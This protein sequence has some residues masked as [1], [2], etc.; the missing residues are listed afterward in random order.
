MNQTNFKTMKR[1]IKFRAWNLDMKQMVYPTLKFGRN[2]WPCTYRRIT[3]TDS[4]TKI[5]TTTEEVSIDHI[6]QDEETYIVMQ[7]T[8]LKDK[9][10]VEIFEGDVCS[11]R[12][13]DPLMTEQ[14]STDEDWSII[15]KVVF[16]RDYCGF[17][18]KDSAYCTFF[19]LY[20][21]DAEIEVIGNIYDNESN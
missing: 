9:N 2:I 15:M 14:F 21:I 4:G 12:A 17:L 5:E 3:Q 19:D 13:K 7:Y 20:S 10:G 11:V 16:D 1:E 8:G 18:L 6:L